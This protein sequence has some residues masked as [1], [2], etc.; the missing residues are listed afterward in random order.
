MTVALADVR[1]DDDN[2]IVVV[3][4][5]I[6]LEFASMTDDEDHNNDVVFETAS[7][8]RGVGGAGGVG[9]EEA[10][11]EGKVVGGGVDRDVDVVV[12]VVMDWGVVGDAVEKIVGGKP[13]GVGAGVPG[14]IMS[15][16]ATNMDE[17]S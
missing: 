8:V 17:S 11:C 13:A 12:V 10:V 15:V 14:S 3:D 1:V 4:D 2:A 9:V 16:S 6:T 7:A 5:I